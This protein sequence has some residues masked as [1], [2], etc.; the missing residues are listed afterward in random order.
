MRGVPQ[1]VQRPVA[2]GSNVDQLADRVGIEI[3]QKLR[4]NSRPM[5]HD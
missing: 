5:L 1:F 2:E 3:S 4:S